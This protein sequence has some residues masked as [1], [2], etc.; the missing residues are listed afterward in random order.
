MKR[1][2][3]ITHK[4]EYL[5]SI[6]AI[7]IV[8]LLLVILN[9][10]FSF[11]SSKNSNIEKANIISE[12]M[13]QNFEDQLNQI[14]SF[15]RNTFLNEKFLDL[16]DDCINNKK[17]IETYFSSSIQVSSS[18]VGGSCYIPRI[19]DEL[20][21]DNRIYNGRFD[22]FFNVNTNNV[23][24]FLLEIVNTSYLDEYSKGK[25]YPIYD[26]NDEIND[27]IVFARNVRDIRQDSYNE[28]LG[29]GFI[30]V[31]KNT[32]LK[33][34]NLTNTLNGFDSM[35]AVND[36][37]LFTTDNSL[38]LNNNYIYKSSL[39]FNNY[40]LI[41]YYDA[42]NIFKDNAFIFTLETLIYLF[43]IVAF[44]I[45]YHYL[46]KDKIKSLNYLFDNFDK[47]KNQIELKQL[48]YT[49]NDSEVNKVIESYNNMVSSIN[50]LN[51]KIYEEKEA[52]NQLKLKNKEIEIESLYSQINKHFII[53]ILSVI[54]SLINL[55][56]IEKAN[57]CLESLSDYL[58][59]SLSFTIKETTIK[60]ELDSVK[61]Y[62]NLQLIRYQ[63]IHVYYVID[64]ASLSYVIP[65]LILQPLVEN[66]FIHG[67]KNK[68]GVI[69]IS[70][71]LEK[72]RILIAVRNDGTIDNDT[73]MSINS[74][75]KK[76]LENKL[77]NHG[78]ALSNI[79]KRMNLF[80]KEGAD[81]YLKVEQNK[82]Y[83]IIEIK[84]KEKLC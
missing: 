9:Y 11:E 3:G 53:N 2:T 72:D 35:I 15:S 57:Y 48:D 77:G 37:I 16:Q 34:F 63:D 23:K 36:N 14:S 67:L 51:I 17:E 60:N 81:L 76:G 19:G 40:Y 8:F 32:F 56:D 59:Y 28:M 44:L 50:N 7:N 82:T 46:H 69:V 22:V 58:R 80:Y 12:N 29:I 55:K 64:E 20:N 41:T 47:N 38:K 71:F 30:V 1:K 42:S 26:V 6:I 73:L 25:I 70:L 4:K 74:N 66:A 27:F 52:S 54:R 62:V 39:N 75:I 65:K 31:D 45:I 18:I 24:S 5:I 49:D 84:T 61:N 83:A 13:R 10:T 79:Y 68:K 43:I 21:I 78:V 33:P